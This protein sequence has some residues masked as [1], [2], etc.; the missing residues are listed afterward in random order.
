MNYQKDPQKVDPLIATPPPNINSLGQIHTGLGPINT[1]LGP[2]NTGL[3]PI[4][5]GLG[6]I[7]DRIIGDFINKITDQD[8]INNAVIDPITQ[9]IKPCIY[10]GCILYFIN[11]GFLFF[12]IYLLLRKKQI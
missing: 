9:R 2:I 7:T 6:P 11:I 4:N 8:K 5:T 3:G 12:I 1:G 10:V